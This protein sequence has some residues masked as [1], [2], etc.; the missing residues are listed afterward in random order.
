M[1]E[2][3]ITIEACVFG[4]RYAVTVQ[5]RSIAWPSM[6][7][8]THVDADKHAKALSAHHGWQVVDKTGEAE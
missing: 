8:R 7:F 2:R 3:S 4:G 6:E 1:T 5:P